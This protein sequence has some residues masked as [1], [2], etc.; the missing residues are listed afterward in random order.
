[1]TDELGADSLKTDQLND[2]LIV[3]PPHLNLS[4][5]AEADTVILADM[6]LHD[7]KGNVRLQ[8]QALSITNMSTSSKHLLFPGYG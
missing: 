6:R 2:R 7:F 1:M 3:M 5:K 4:F 8:D